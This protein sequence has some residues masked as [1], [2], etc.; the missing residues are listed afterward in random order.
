MNKKIYVNLS[1][2]LFTNV[3]SL[4]ISIIVTFILPKILLPAEYGEWQFYIF[5]YNYL[6][7]FQFGLGDG[8]YL[9]YGKY[10]FLKI[11]VKIRKQILLLYLILIIIETFGIL[12]LNMFIVNEKFEK[13]FIYFLILLFVIP[14]KEII[15][16]IAEITGKLKIILKGVLFERTLY[17]IFILLFYYFKLNTNILIFLTFLSH[18]LGGMYTILIVK[19][20]KIKIENKIS[21]NDIGEFLKNIKIGIKLRG[22]LFLNSL[23]LGFLKMILEK[24]YGFL[25]FGY[26]SLTFSLISVIN[27]FINSINIGIYSI[28][29]AEKRE[30]LKLFYKKISTIIEIFSVIILIIIP[31]ITKNGKHWFSAYEM[32]FKYLEILIPSV[33]FEIKNSFLNMQFLKLIR[34]EE[35]GIKINIITIILFFIGFF[36]IN[37]MFINIGINIILYYFIFCNYLRKIFLDIKIIKKMKLSYMKNWLVE[38]IILSIYFTFLVKAI[39]FKESVFLYIGLLFFL[40][41]KIIRRKKI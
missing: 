14:Y 28:L 17:L 12:F 3:Y 13:I 8:I 22:I 38:W 41:G 27:F 37:F 39:S 6:K 7:Y 18:L 20:F 34:L 21:K 9:R 29:L 11:L 24:K 26:I 25:Y 1:L 40:I 32:S 19:G 30:N 23:N 10:S 2:S 15:Y 16:L 35:E 5:Y 36:I 4:L 31:F 33:I